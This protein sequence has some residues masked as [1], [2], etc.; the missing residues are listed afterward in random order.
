MANVADLARPGDPLDRPLNT[1]NR[2][3]AGTP[4]ALALTPAFSGELVLNTTDGTLWFARGIAS[5]DWIIA[6]IG[7]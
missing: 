4:I 1:P 2:K 3:V 5:N 7:V 6:V